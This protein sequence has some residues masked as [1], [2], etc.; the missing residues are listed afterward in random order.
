LEKQICAV[1]KSTKNHQCKI[2][3]FV[4]ALASMRTCKAHLGLVEK[5]N[6]IK[7][8]KGTILLFKSNMPVVLS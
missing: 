4:K 2:E 6:E 7:E 8:R 1:L 5:Q 3:Q